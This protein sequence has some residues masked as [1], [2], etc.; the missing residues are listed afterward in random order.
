MI[1]KIFLMTAALL[2]LWTI[3]ATA[4]QS[5]KFGDYTVH[6]SAF[7]TDQLTPEVAKYY[8]IPRSK[9]RVM[10]NISVLKKK[11]D[12]TLGTPVRAKITGAAKNLS[13]QLRELQLR[14]VIEENAIY[15]I[16]DTPIN[17]EETLKYS[18]QI[19]P[20]GEAAPYQLSFQE[21][22]YTN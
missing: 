20:E 6:Y 13:E 21:Q 18:F 14:E 15:Y 2:A 12:K 22:F 8:Q 10:V 17:N 16:G 4:E 11:N 3:A 5:Q 19:T 1:K 7:T 9:N